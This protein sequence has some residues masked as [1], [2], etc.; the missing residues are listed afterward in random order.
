[1]DVSASADFEKGHI[2]GAKNVQMSQFDPENKLLAK[3]AELP[4]AVV[5][6]TGTGLRR[7][8]QAPGQGRLQAGVLARRRHCRLAA[9]SLPLVKGRGLSWQ[10][11]VRPAPLCHN[12]PF[13][14]FT[15]VFP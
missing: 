4:V 9:A 12:P 8:R 14:H 1:M 10:S 7:R 2:A 6:R 5:C 15:G 3:V 13:T 11:P